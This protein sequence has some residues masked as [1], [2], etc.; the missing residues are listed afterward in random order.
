MTRSA[1]DVFSISEET[2]W[3]TTR[4]LPSPGNP[5][6]VARELLDISQMNDT[7]CW[8]RGDFY[9]WVGTH[10]DV[11]PDDDV[12]AWLYRQTENALFM[13]AGPK[14]AEASWSPTKKKIGD[15]TEALGAGV[16]QRSGTELAEDGS[17]MVAFTNGVL[18]LATME[19]LDHTP[20]RF[21][22][23]SLPVAYSGDASAVRWLGF[24]DQV[25]EGDVDRIAL[26]QEWF[27][28]V[29]CGGTE[30]QKILSMF[31]PKRCGKGTVMRVLVA[32]LGEQYVAAPSTLDSL[33]G[34]FGEQK[35][36]GAR[37]AIFSDVQWVGSHLAEAVGI[38]LAI[39][40]E[41][42]RDVARKN[43]TEW[44]GKLPTRFM[45]AGNDRP[46]F[47][48][49]SGALPGRMEQLQ[50]RVSFYGRENIGL[51]GELLAELAG[52]FNWALEGWRRLE[53]QG[54]KFTQSTLGT[55]AA[56][57]VERN[58]SPITAFVKDECV[59]GPDCSIEFDELFKEYSRW[60][61][62]ERV[63]GVITTA[64]VSRNLTSAFPM[65]NTKRNGS[66]RSG[67]TYMTYGLRM[68]DPGEE[69]DANGAL[70]SADRA[71]D[72]ALPPD[73]ADRALLFDLPFRETAGQGVDGPRGPRG[74]CIP[75]ENQV[76]NQTSAESTRSQFVETEIEKIDGPP[77]PPG[78][79]PTLT[80]ENT[81]PC[82]SGDA[83]S[84]FS[85]ELWDDWDEDDPGPAD[86]PD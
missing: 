36:I 61:A 75:L 55:E 72:R 43:R 59:V 45:F 78:P 38:L 84:T 82:I 14:P 64:S 26:L 81:G 15:L 6:A 20:K 65:V 23:H 71:P 67:R 79:P 83:R 4:L 74:P 39:S 12:K 70:V 76:E 53:R 5:M 29:L 21:N 32:L 58:A 44:K 41:D 68:R 28:Y 24:L 10:W 11:W 77:G 50:F 80:S 51:T 33:A 1:E 8:W 57:E 37:L 27:G 19:L 2:G 3:P 47:P 52:I 30:L 18:E 46:K 86:E 7:I 34:P 42:H 85:P 16:L 60:R 69:V 31:G 63:D 40:G 9:R 54:G 13:T 48:N 49:V 22:L 25:L 56:A 66:S 35:L 17:G 62:V 73:R